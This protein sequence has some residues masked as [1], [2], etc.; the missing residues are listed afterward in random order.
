M[1]NPYEEFTIEELRDKVQKE[2]AVL[3][4]IKT[5][6]KNNENNLKQQAEF[7]KKEQADLIQG[8]QS[9][10]KLINMLKKDIMRMAYS[11]SLRIDS[12][13]YQSK[14]VAIVTPSSEPPTSFITQGASKPTVPNSSVKKEAKPTKV[15]SKIP[16]KPSGI[17]PT[18]RVTI[19][20]PKTPSSIKKPDNSNNLLFDDLP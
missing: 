8:V 4:E 9:R 20:V 12:A 17:K 19:V 13:E 3:N 11:E 7:L 2:Q 5:Q 10:M 14:E 15:N 1:D 6:S 16:S 18:Q